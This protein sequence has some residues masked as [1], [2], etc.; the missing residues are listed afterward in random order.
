VEQ[1]FKTGIEGEICEAFEV[2]K[3]TLDNTLKDDP[4]NVINDAD[5]FGEVLPHTTSKCSQINLQNYFQCHVV[6]DATPFVQTCRQQVCREPKGV[7]CA[8]AEAYAETCR[9]LGLC[10]DWRSKSLCPYQECP[11]GFEYKPCGTGCC[12]TCANKGKQQC[13]FRKTEGC[14]CPNGQV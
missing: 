4:C 1:N 13:K 9:N 11:H 12:P 6:V 5:I 8:I 2:T 10:L 3:C 7:V 14:F